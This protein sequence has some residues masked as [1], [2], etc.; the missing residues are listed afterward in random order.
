MPLIQLMPREKNVM[1]PVE[2]LRVSDRFQRLRRKLPDVLQAK[3]N[4][5]HTINIL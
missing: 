2:M 5:V 4:Q 1:V 3:T